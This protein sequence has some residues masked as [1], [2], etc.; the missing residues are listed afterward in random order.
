M[1][2]ILLEELQERHKMYLTLS[3]RNIWRNK[4]R[5]IIVAASVFFAV[6]LSA[7]MRSGQLG[8]YSYMIDSSA[9]LFTG[10]LQIQGNGYWEKRSLDESIFL[11]PD[12]YAKLESVQYL[13]Y[14]TPRLEAFAL[15]SHDSTTKVSQVIGIDPKREN[16]MTDVFDRLIKGNPI[17]EQSRGLL[18]GSGLAEMLGAGLGDSLVVYGQ[19][20]HGQIAAAI[21]PVTGILKLPFKAMDNAMILMSLATAQDVFSCP[22]R[23]TS[24]PMM[25]EDNRFLNQ[26]Q[27]DISGFL[28]K[29]QVI[30]SWEEMMPELLQN[31]E[32]D[33]VSGL[34]MLAIL[35]IVIG[36]GVFG[37]VMMMVSERAR[38]LAILVSLG[39]RKSKLLMIMAI[40]TF[41]LSFVGVIMGILGSIPAI[42]Y[43]VYNPIELTG[44]AA[45]LYDQ[46]SIEPIMNFSAQPSVFIS[47][48][49]V[50]FVIALVTIIYPII[51][52]RN[53][54]PATTIR[55]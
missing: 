9:K 50:V 23:I 38:E 16:D 33:N 21:L 40:E 27:E 54:D 15:I 5:T 12:L 29:D 30:M 10:Y 46:L 7:L 3:W 37:T 24:L 11:D 43:F 8:S 28:P 36:F 4:K 14:F 1:D 42:Y 51:F 17:D 34:I 45:E 6:I 44:G 49:L 31:I 22:N 55:G 48:A 32:V 52:I 47:Q 2:Y 18:V 25:I 53:M 19:G 26:V 35:Y 20:Y 39:M 13:T 41:L